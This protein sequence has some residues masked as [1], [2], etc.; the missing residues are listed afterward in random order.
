MENFKQLQ[1]K[2]ENLE[3]EKFNKQLEIE[4]I[5]VEIENST[6]L[7]QYTFNKDKDN[8]NAV[9]NSETLSLLKKLAENIN[10][11]NQMSNKC[12]KCY[13]AE[14][15]D[16]IDESDKGTTCNLIEFAD[17]FAKFIFSEGWEEFLSINGINFS[18]EEDE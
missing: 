1:Q 9:L 2:I 18:K 6:Q 15:C 4:D 5:E 14:D 10:I 12:S 7:L 11:Y 13:Y 16:Y 17:S 3:Q 8:A